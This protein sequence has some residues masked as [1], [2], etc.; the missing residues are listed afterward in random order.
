MAGVLACGGVVTVIVLAAL[1]LRVMRDMTRQRRK[2]EAAI[3]MM[4]VMD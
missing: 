4:E 2:L 1:T 3:K